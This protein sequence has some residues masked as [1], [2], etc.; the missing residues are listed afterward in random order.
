MAGNPNWVKGGASPN[1]SGRKRLTEA[2][3]VAIKLRAELQPALVKT[4]ANIAM[5]EKAANSD[6]ITA[7]KALLLETPKDFGQV[8]VALANPD[9]SGIDFSKVSADEAKL[10]RDVLRKLNRE[11]EEE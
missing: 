10:V 9:G 11:K 1:P 5:N 8:T 6:R 4:L 3:E 2:E 7:C